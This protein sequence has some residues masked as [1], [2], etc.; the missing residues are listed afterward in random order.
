MVMSL[1]VMPAA[2]MMAMHGLRSSI[3]FATSGFVMAALGFTTGAVLLLSAP[4][5]TECVILTAYLVAMIMVYALGFGWGIES[6][7]RLLRGA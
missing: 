4:L 3:K 6:R 2:I 1:L 7:A 5:L